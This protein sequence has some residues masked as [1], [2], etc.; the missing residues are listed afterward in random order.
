MDPYE[1]WLVEARALIAS[2]E[3]SVVR[4]ER[5]SVGHFSPNAYK[6]N[7]WTPRTKVTWG[8]QALVRG[9]DATEDIAPDWGEAKT[10]KEALAWLADAQDATAVRLLSKHAWFEHT[11]RM[12][13]AGGSA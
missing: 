11:D 4:I 12:R 8:I 10:R 5:P 7:E 1:V 6:D 3:W 9:E 13:A 2:I